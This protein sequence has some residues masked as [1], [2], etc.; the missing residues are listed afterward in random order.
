MFGAP[1]QAGRRASPLGTIGVPTRGQVDYRCVSSLLRLA[2][3]GPVEYIVHAGSVLHAQRNAIT[4]ALRG[5]WLLF[6]D[7]DMVIHP[8]ALL[9]LLAHGRDIVGGLCFRR[10]PPYAPCIARWDG[11]HMR[12][13]DVP[14]GGL[15]PVDGIGMGVTLIRRRVFETLG[16][17]CFAFRDGLS[18]D[19]AF[20]LAAREAGFDVMC[21]PAVQPGH[22]SSVVVDAA[23]HHAWRASQREAATT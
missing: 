12:T 6:V 17:G 11:A 9:R 21:D 19:Y 5:E 2:L 22:V 13:L 14:T 20:C 7:D 8:D 18:E 15:I 16:S 10:T 23:V 1:G 3:P 4:D